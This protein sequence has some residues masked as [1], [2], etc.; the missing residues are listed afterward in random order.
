MSL[1]RIRRYVT[2]SDSTICHRLGFDAARRF[3]RRRPP[4]EELKGRDR[5]ERPPSLPPSRR[6]LTAPAVSTRD[7]PLCL[8]RMCSNEEGPAP[9]GQPQPLCPKH[10]VQCRPISQLSNTW[11]PGTVVLWDTSARCSTPP[12][13]CHESLGA[14]IRRSRTIPFG[15]PKTARAAARAPGA[16]DCPRAGRRKGGAAGNGASGPR[17]AD[18][19]WGG[20]DGGGGGL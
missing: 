5:P 3:Q 15:H 20:G 14:Q 13:R 16:A 17:E 12:R 1:T 7:W 4:S 18:M 19:G 6:S 2:D 11:R 8:E 10:A 9:P